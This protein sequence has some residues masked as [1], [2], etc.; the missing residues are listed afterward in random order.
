MHVRASERVNAEPELTATF[1][2]V[3]GKHG[4]LSEVCK[5]CRWLPLASQSYQRASR[6]ASWHFRL[7]KS[8]LTPKKESDSVSSRDDTRVIR[9]KL[10]PR[11]VSS[12]CIVAVA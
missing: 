4:D 10:H 5:R 7:R 11:K 12:L 2:R 8:R 9:G 6:E 3:I 1:R